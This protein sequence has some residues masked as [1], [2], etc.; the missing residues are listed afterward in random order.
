MQHLLRGRRLMLPLLG[1]SRA[2]P[3]P[4]HLQEDTSHST[5]MKGVLRRR[6]THGVQQSA[7]GL[8]HERDC[9]DSG[10][11]PSHSLYQQNDTYCQSWMCMH[12]VDKLNS[13]QTSGQWAEQHWTNLIE[14]KCKR[15]MGPKVQRFAKSSSRDSGLPPRSPANTG[16]IPDMD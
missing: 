12:M 9:R 16:C 6:R 15:K 2:V 8:L 5:R 4:G 7:S 11:M 1:C 14:M 10:H 3:S 13:G